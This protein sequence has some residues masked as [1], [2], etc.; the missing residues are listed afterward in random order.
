[1]KVESTGK[2]TGYVMVEQ[3][4]SVDYTTREAGFIEKASVEVLAEVLARHAACFKP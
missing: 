3:V 4:K 1:V 2:I